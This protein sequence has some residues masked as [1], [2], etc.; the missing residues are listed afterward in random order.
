MESTSYDVV[1][2]IRD[3]FKPCFRQVWDLFVS[4]YGPDWEQYLGHF[5]DQ[6]GHTYEPCRAT[7]AALAFQV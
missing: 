7:V 3:Q 5:L 2:L 1:S 4:S 6:L